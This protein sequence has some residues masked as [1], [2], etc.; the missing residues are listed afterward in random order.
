MLGL[1]LGLSL[2]SRRR[3]RFDP[4]A[5][6]EALLAPGATRLE[7]LWPAPRFWFSDAAGTVPWVSGPVRGWRSTAGTLFAQP[8]NA[9]FAPSVGA[10]PNGNAALSF[11]GVDDWLQSA[12]AVD[13]SASDKVM[14]MSGTRTSVTGTRIAFELGVNT[15]NTNGTFYLAEPNDTSISSS[16]AFAVRGTVLRLVTTGTFGTP[17]SSVLTGYAD[18]GAPSYALRRNG[19]AAGSGSDSLGSGNFASG[20][21]L[22]LGSRLTGTP[23]TASFRFAGLM[24]PMVFRGGPLPDLTTIAA[25]EAIINQHVG[26]Y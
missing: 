10:F 6:L 7:I 24:G 1:G 11:D 18:I 12:A 13:F 4:W 3:R 8:T 5:S 9:D 2:G 20:L 16:S 17:R 26:A 22:N 19:T 25:A 15:A 23:G 21:R 14:T